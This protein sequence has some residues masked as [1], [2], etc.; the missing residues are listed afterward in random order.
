MFGSRELVRIFPET[1]CAD[2]SGVVNPSD[3]KTARNVL[4][5]G[6]C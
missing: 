4:G 5:C 3:K 6:M 2:T 1:V